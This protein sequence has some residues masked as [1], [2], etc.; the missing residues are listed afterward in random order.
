MGN[1]FINL[2]RVTTIFY[3]LCTVFIA[4]PLVS[5][6]VSRTQA[7]VLMGNHV[8]ADAIGVSLKTSSAMLFITLVI[9]TPAAYAY[10]RNQ[11]KGKKVLNVVLDLP[12]I[13]PPAVAGL[14]LLMTFGRRGWIGGLLSYMDIQL[15]FTMAAVVMAQL[16][17]GLPIYI[18]TAAQGFM[19]VDERLELTAMT[20]GD[21]R[22]KAFL[23][24]TLPLASSSILT[25]AIMAWARGLAE[26]GATIMFAGNLQG[27]TQT[28]PLAI[29]SAM[30]TDTGVALGIAQVMV[31]VS[32]IL[33]V[34]V[35]II[36]KGRRDHVKM[37]D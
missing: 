24:I 36:D 2:K 25:G 3:A 17:V 20:L 23:R 5:L 35:H 12:L 14:L 7:S 29:Y 8:L 11:F 18:K 37:S 16:F 21:S 22:L 32:M 4:L 13:L 10:A 33:L 9:G 6:V 34:T 30:E 15:P 31:V 1:S 26:F 27:L 28:L 19:G